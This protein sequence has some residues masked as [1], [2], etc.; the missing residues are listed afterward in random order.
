MTAIPKSTTLTAPIAPSDTNDTYATHYARYGNG[1]LMSAANESARE[2]IPAD[3]REEGM[4]V[5][6]LD[7]NS[8][9]RLL[10]GIAN[11]DWEEVTMTPANIVGLAALL[12]AKEDS[13]GNPPGLGYTITSDTLGARSWVAL[14][15]LDLS[16]YEL[17]SEKGQANGY[18]E[19]D[20]SGLVPS[21]QLP[22]Y[23]DDVIEVANYA[24]LPGTGE[25][26]KIYIL[27]TPYT[28]GGITSS[29]FRWSGSAYA[30][31]VAS[32]GTTDAVTEG[33]TNLYYTNARASAAA[34][35]QSVSGKTGTVTLT[36][37][38][39]GLGSVDNTADT[40]KPV[41]TPQQTALNL[42]SD[43]VTATTGAVISF[44]APQVYN[45]VASPSA[46]N[47]TDDLTGAIIGVIQKIYHNHSVAPTF[48]AGW[49][50]MGTG[51]YTTSTLN[52]IYCEWVSGTRVEYWIS[53]P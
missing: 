14:S 42:K 15:G 38:D 6:Q 34:P 31:I 51:A 52:V 53:K 21:A 30:A 37:S 50:K 3:R 40:A 4:W 39:V 9:W 20:G 23:V 18:A 32:P 17:K 44:A 10:G 19:L 25:S 41:S 13:L 36:A 29:Q 1:G 8:Y 27:A 49:V 28:S 5:Q 22:S 24:A 47:I 35:V 12:L 7:D 33:S 43:K 2:A 48:P 45:S 26:S 46:S 16:P 11:G